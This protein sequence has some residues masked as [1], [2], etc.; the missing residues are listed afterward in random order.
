MFV[1]E[2][3][4]IFTYLAV[5][6]R[7]ESRKSSDLHARRKMGKT[8]EAGVS[9]GSGTQR[10]GVEKCW[11][12]IYINVTFPSENNITSFYAREAVLNRTWY[13]T[14]RKNRTLGNNR[15]WSIVMIVKK[16]KGKKAKSYQAWKAYTE[17]IFTGILRL[18]GTN[19]TVTM[20]KCNL[21]RTVKWHSRKELNVL[22]QLQCEIVQWKWK[23]IQCLERQNSGALLECIGVPWWC[24]H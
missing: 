3:H 8:A 12:P 2:L 24:Y 18:D 9:E 14:S 22:L 1:E 5:L 15:T 16:E 21:A 13:S 10:T 17:N 6:I 19:T 20:E 23:C 7:R 11:S 4:L